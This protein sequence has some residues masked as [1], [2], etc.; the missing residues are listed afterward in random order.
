M[1]REKDEPE[2]VEAVSVGDDEEAILI[3]GYL[4]SQGIPAVVEGPSSTPFPDDLGAFGMSRVMVPPDRGEEARR[5]IA[6]R[7]RRGPH[8]VGE[9]EL[10]AE[11]E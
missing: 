2:W 6:E 9:E 3:A 11:D 7:K 8:R 4:Q 5:L 10:E 1:K